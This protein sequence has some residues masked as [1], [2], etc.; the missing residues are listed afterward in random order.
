MIPRIRQQ[1]LLKLAQCRI[2]GSPGLQRAA[3]RQ[4]PT[5]PL[6]GHTDRPLR[7]PR[8]AFSTSHILLQDQPKPPQQETTTAPA[9]PA[10]PAEPP[11]SKS[12]PPPKPR[13]RRRL[14]LA[15]T[16]LLIGTAAGSSLRLVLS[17]PEP[18]A[19]GTEE[20]AYTISVLHTQAAALPIVAELSADPDWTSW[21]AYESMPAP[22]AATHACASSLAGSRG[23]G[24]YQ[25]IFQHRPTGDVVAVVYLGAGTAGWPGVAHGGCVAT[26]LDECCGRAASAARLAARTGFTARLEVNYLRPALSNGFCVVRAR[27]R[28]EEELDPSERGKGSYKAL[29]DATLEDAATGR[30]CAVAEAL[31]IGP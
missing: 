23:L 22:H 7:Q 12:P 29:V 5:S 17:P 28:P 3:F 18:P 27:C 14:L 2:A 19:P 1:Q 15:A 9:P 31:F 25:R 6:P 13:R 21:Q 4:L 8:R 20:D 30:V 26:L 11:T 10:P 16:F 24:G